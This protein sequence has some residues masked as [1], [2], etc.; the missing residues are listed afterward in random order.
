MFKRTPLQREALASRRLDGET[1]SMERI[2][3]LEALELASQLCLNV[4]LHTGALDVAM[5]ASQA[6]N[7]IHQGARS[8]SEFYTF[9]PVAK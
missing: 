7:V 2:T 8:A 5:N 1:H 4:W 3:G 6:R 9:R